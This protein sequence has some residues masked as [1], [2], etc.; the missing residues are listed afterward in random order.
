[1]SLNIKNDEA[2]R[3]A[4]ELAALTGETLTAAVTL[5]LHERLDRVRRENG[6][7]LA[8][9]LLAIGRDTA[10]RLKEPFRSI[11]HG[12]LLYADDGLPQ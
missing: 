7:S 5:A 11:D 8:D 1:M 4:Q 6:A 10:P 12:D 9:R 2:H 3:L